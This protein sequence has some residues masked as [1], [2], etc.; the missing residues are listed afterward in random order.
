MSY[1]R[2][3]VAAKLRRWERYLS[4]YE[5]PRWEHIPDIGLY[6]EQAL[7]LLR[8]YLDYLPPELMEEQFITAAA[9]NNYVRKKI[10]PE[11]VKKKYYRT[12]LAY[13]IMICTLK[14]CMSISTVRLLVPN[15]LSEEELKALYTSYVTRHRLTCDMFVSEARKVAAKILDMEENEISA[16]SVEELIMTSAVLSGFS[17]ILSEKLLLLNG[18]AG[19]ADAVGAEEH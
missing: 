18:S 11:P 1:D 12:H 16:D 2:E 6:M 17:R 14:Q 15:D 9:V 5:L 3:L 7:S 4:S 8:S 19:N 13:L 10:M